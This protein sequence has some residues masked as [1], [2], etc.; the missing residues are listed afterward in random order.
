MDYKKQDEKM[1]KNIYLFFLLSFFLISFSFF[2]LN[3]KPLEVKELDVN[4]IVGKGVGF[5]LNSSALTFGKI[6]LG[7]SSARSIA[8]DNSYNFPIEVNIFA[9]KEIRKFIKA[10][11]KIIINSKENISIPITVYVPKDSVLGNYSGKIKLK[12]YS[13]PKN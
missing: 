3:S 4:F 13:Q 5:D 6:P 1:K 9:T 10:P 2:I 12:M 11:F 7:G 8:V